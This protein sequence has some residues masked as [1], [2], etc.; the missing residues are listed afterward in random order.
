MHDRWNDVYDCG[1]GTRTSQVEECPIGDED[2]ARTMVVLGD[3]HVGQW[4]PGL[5]AIGEES[6]YRVLPLIKYG[7]TPFGVDQE[8]LSRTWVR[9][10]TPHLRARMAIS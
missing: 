10:V 8:H 3:S 1:A 6:G 7:C 9:H 2:A 5:D 4:L